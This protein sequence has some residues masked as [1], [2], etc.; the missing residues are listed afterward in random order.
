MRLRTRLLSSSA[1]WTAPLWL[2]IVLFYYAWALHSVTGTFSRP[3][4][5]LHWAASVVLDATE[6]FYAFA[7]ALAAALGAWEA[8]RIRKDGVWDLAPARSRYRI[9]AGVLAPTVAAA[10]LML[11]VPTAMA[12]VEFRPALDP[13][14]LLPVAVGIALVCSFTVAGF[15]IGLRVPRAIAAPLLAAGGWYLV[16]FTV[17]YAEPAWPGNVLTQRWYLDFGAYLKGEALLMPVLFCGGIAAA[18]AVWWIRGPAPFVRYALRTVAA[19]LAVLLATVS[20]GAANAWSIDPPATAGHAP[21]TCTGRLPTVCMASYAGA[22]D[23]L[24]QVRSSLVATLT[25]LR[26]AGVEVAMPRSVRDTEGRPG[27]RSSDR[28]W[29]LPLTR[30]VDRND[31]RTVYVRYS[32]AMMA[33]RFPCRLPDSFGAAKEPAYIVN[34]DA[35]KLWVARRAGVQEP[36]LK[37]RESQ[38]QELEN[39]D[40]VLAKV[41]ERAESAERLRRDEQKEW[42]GRE[43]AKACRLATGRPAP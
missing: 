3:R 24:P 40:E 38:Y 23:R 22:A 34:A 11:V 29:W 4:A 37:W 41:K 33:V 32:A 19:A 8:G 18:I 36:F 13:R 12:L 1:L 39:G 6:H 30:Q 10:S 20:A 27:G 43:L 35:A 28:E 9:A 17:T 25:G 42:Y 14:A 16:A 2:G 7:Y 31:G 26:E 21:E 5:E 15:A